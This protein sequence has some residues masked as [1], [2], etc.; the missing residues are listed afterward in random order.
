MK[1]VTENVTKV[2]TGAVETLDKPNSAV[3]LE[4][5]ASGG[6]ETELERTAGG[7]AVSEGIRDGMSGGRGNSSVPAPSP[8][9][10]LPSD[11]QTE[12]RV[13]RLVGFKKLQSLLQ[14]VH[15]YFKDKVGWIT[16]FYLYSD[17][18]RELA[19]P[20][21]KV[22][23]RDNPYRR[24]QLT[25]KASARTYKRIRQF[26][27]FR[28]L[29]DFKVASIGVTMPKFMSE[30]LA[31][32]GKYGRHLAWRLFDGFWDEDLPDTL[33]LD[34]E[35]G[36]HTNLHLWRS[37][38]PTEAHYHFHTLIPNYGL[39]MSDIKD[40]NGDLAFELRKW[41]WHRQRGGRE[42][43][44]SDS[45]LGKL[46]ELWL[47]R[48]A[49]FCQRHGIEFK[50]Q[51]VNIFVDYVDVWAKL[52]H[53]LNYNGRHWSENYAEYSNKYPDSQDPP[54][55]LKG[56]ENRARCKGWWSNLK[57]ITV[58]SKEKE[59][60]SPYTGEGMTYIQRIGFEPLTEERVL[61][62]VEF[63]KGQSVEGSF[64]RQD[65]AWLEGV[66]HYNRNRLE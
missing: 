47:D 32:K 59:K 1:T 36:S 3:L 28:K 19:Y 64:T 65:L 45:Q 34:I 37:E 21:V 57:G 8:T 30:Y 61:G 13:T 44:F 33:G 55:W 38:V 25:H 27:E 9:N 42:V 10:A 22:S 40:E 6:V 18:D 23:H 17:E 63:V 11:S 56:Y 4:H 46:K 53:K 20:V 7:P 35:L 43:P 58:E 15:S 39:V 66:M 5:G 54:E 12:V 2:N 41:P 48:L 49:R 26:A 29:D 60:L 62:Y 31:S 52:L 51:K 24:H 50:A 16:H 14:P